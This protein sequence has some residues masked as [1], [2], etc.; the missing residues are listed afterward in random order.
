MAKSISVVVDGKIYFGANKYDVL[1]S[2]LK[3]GVDQ[4]EAESAL[5]PSKQAKAKPLTEKQKAAIRK[6]KI[7]AKANELISTGNIAKQLAL[8]LVG[9]NAKEQKNG[10]TKLTNKWEKARALYTKTFGECESR[11]ATERAIN[12][13]LTK[14]KISLHDVETEKE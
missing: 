6:D 7:N 11:R 1:L 3:A 10:S 12:Q 13:L 14:H 4:T 2:M 9:N 8:L 5:K